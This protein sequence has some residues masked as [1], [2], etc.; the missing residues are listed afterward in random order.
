MARQM[1]K[2]SLIF[3]A[4]LIS[5]ILLGMSNHA[6]ADYGLSINPDL[7]PTPTSTA[8]ASLCA[9]VIPLTITGVE[10]MHESGASYTSMVNVGTTI[11]PGE[12]ALWD[13]PNDFGLSSLDLGGWVLRVDTDP[14]GTLVDDFS[15]LFFVVPE[16]I[17][18]AVA[19]IGSSLA[20]L[21]VYRRKGVSIKESNNNQQ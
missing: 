9:G 11:N 4:V 5:S 3:F 10:I 13:I 17:I 21:A 8:T 1:N 18:G 15:V 14:S 16:S 6:Y 7:L 2:H 20:V 19:V 12:C